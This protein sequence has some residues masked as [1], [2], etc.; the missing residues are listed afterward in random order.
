MHLIRTVLKLEP[1]MIRVVGGFG[2]ADNEEYTHCHCKPSLE[3]N[4]KQKQ[5]TVK[6]SQFSSESL[7]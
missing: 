2:T 5:C 6:M 4:K 1:L 7:T 3:G